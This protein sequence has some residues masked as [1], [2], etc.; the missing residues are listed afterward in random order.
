VVGLV[1]VW[2]VKKTW[3]VLLA[4]VGIGVLL[5][6]PYLYSELTSHFAN[7]QTGVNFFLHGGQSFERIRK[8]D[9]VLYFFPGFYSRLLFRETFVSGWTSLYEEY[10]GPTR[11][12]IMNS[13]AFWGIVAGS[14]VIAFRQVRRQKNWW[15]AGSLLLFVVMFAI[16]RV[17][18][19]DKP[20]YYLNNFT[21]FIFIWLGAVLSFIKWWQVRALIIAVMIVIGSWALWH[22]PFYNRY[23][24]FARFKRYVTQLQSP[25]VH[26][27]LLSQELER[28]MSYFFDSSVMSATPSATAEYNLLVCYSY[29]ACQE[30]TPNEYKI[31][32]AFK[33]NLVDPVDFSFMYPQLDHGGSRGWIDHNLG[34][35]Q[36]KQKF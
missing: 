25:K 30:Y 24:D 8:P 17:Y 9:Y 27:V 31:K 35:F 2:R 26:V 4:A 10:T 15:L 28:P 20:D 11:A 36:V 3:P 13:V 14:G 34:V 19:G 1:G 5:L 7:F 21:P 12:M 32:N 22:S 6:S 33:R 18:K 29:Q 16:L 23:E